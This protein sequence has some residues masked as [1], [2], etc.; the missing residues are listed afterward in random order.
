MTP[1]YFPEDHAEE[2]GIMTPRVSSMDRSSE[3]ATNE[4]LPHVSEQ[5]PIF[6]AGI[7]SDFPLPASSPS[8]IAQPAPRAIL[9]P[10]PISRS[11]TSTD[12]AALKSLFNRFPLLLSRIVQSL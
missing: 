7:N 2:W 1:R 6:Q 11:V 8:D 9:F 10:L 12:R 3:P 4:R 5:T